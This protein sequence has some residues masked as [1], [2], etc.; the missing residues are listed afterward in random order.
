MASLR[1][2]LNGNLKK[3]QNMSVATWT[4]KTRMNSDRSYATYYINRPMTSI[5][6]TLLSFAK[7]SMESQF[8]KALT[9]APTA[10]SAAV[11]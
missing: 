7:S 5:S 10:M 8:T 6:K 3:K 1:A 4:L 2:A 11:L 9:K